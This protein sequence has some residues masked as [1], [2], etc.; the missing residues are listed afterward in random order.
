MHTKS[1]QQWPPKFASQGSMCLLYSLLGDS[2]SG[3]WIKVKNWKVIALTFHRSVTFFC[4]LAGSSV[5]ILQNSG[6]CKGAARLQ[7]FERTAS[8]L[9]LKPVGPP[10]RAL[11]HTYLWHLSQACGLIRSSCSSNLLQSA[12][13]TGPEQHT[14]RKVSELVSQ[15]ILLV[16][17]KLRKAVNRSQ[18]IQS[19]NKRLFR[20]LIQNSW[21][22]TQWESALI[23]N[24]P[25]LDN[26]NACNRDSS[27]ATNST[28]NS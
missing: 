17:L 27:H 18:N 1:H 12:L 25:V 15:L 2:T 8:D 19:K 13:C 6:P 24:I 28:K 23:S 16:H 10:E 4:L 22:W 20:H 21:K 3:F 9:N 11:E 5:I 26:A 14:Q 7:S